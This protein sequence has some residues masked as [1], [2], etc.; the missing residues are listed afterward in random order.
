LLRTQANDD[1]IEGKRP[2][3]PVFDSGGATSS[4]LACLSKRAELTG[5][6]TS[7][8]CTNDIDIQLRRC[9]C[10]RRATEKQSTVTASPGLLIVSQPSRLQEACVRV[11]LPV[12]AR[13][14]PLLEATSRLGRG[15]RLHLWP[16]S[17]QCLPTLGALIWSRYYSRCQSSP[18]AQSGRC[19]KGR[20]G[21]TD[22]A[23]CNVVASLPLR[24]LSI[25][26]KCDRRKQL[27]QASFLIW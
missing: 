19:S 13:S 12:P 17:C 18:G 2:A 4:S 3:D 6:V 24:S 21:C 11:H 22:L 25:S 20:Q 27:L 9:V 15:L 1:T 5:T 10:W 16:C 8:H 7:V 14:Q 26:P 23:L